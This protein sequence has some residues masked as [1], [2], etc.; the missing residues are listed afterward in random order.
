MNNSEKME[1]DWGRDGKK[2]LNATK[3]LNGLY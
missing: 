3:D 2:D 1:N